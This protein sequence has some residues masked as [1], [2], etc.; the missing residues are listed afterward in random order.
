MGEI[1]IR[2]I[3]DLLMYV[4]VAG[5]RKIENKISKTSEARVRQTT[6]RK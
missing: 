1:Y 2:A 4:H 6:K 3:R 5:A